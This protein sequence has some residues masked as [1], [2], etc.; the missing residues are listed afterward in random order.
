VG[1]HSFVSLPQSELNSEL[2]SRHYFTKWIKLKM[3]KL[4]YILITLLVAS[5][6]KNSVESLYKNALLDAE[7]GK[8]WS[9]V[10]KSMESAYKM[11][12]NNYSVGM[13]YSV[14][15]IELGKNSNAQTILEKF[16][17]I[18]PNDVAVNMLLG[19]ILFRKSDYSQAFTHF[20]KAYLAHKKSS[21]L[22]KMTIES[23]V[24]ANL[25]KVYTYIPKSPDDSFPDHPELRNDPVLWNNI[26]V[27]K[28]KHTNLTAMQ[29]VGNLMQLKQ[30][31][32]SD[33]WITYNAAAN[34]DSEGRKRLAVRYY[35]QF[36]NLATNSNYKGEE[37]SGVSKR[38]KKLGY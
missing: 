13:L 25:D 16:K 32:P 30:K 8:S 19:K 2:P 15:L 14:A 35:Q 23:G 24:Q 28:T 26:V 4:A 37:V 27:W 31:H 36:I 22:L 10:N 5:C 33:L 18:R 20:E 7:S 21:Y 1:Y 17:K 38:L 6:G 3:K 9:V 11:D 34:H 12:P 29:Y